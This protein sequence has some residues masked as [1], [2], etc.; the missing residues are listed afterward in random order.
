MAIFCRLNK[1]KDTSSIFSYYFLKTIIEVTTILLD[2]R[3]KGKE[4]MV[5][6][7]L[8]AAIEQNT[9]SS[10]AIHCQYKNVETLLSEQAA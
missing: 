5:V 1:V 8:D 4:N 3:R 7:V 6:D 2:T 9:D 10:V